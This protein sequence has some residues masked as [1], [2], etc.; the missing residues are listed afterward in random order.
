MERVQILMSTYNGEKYLKQQLDSILAQTYPNIRIFIRDDG[1][2]DGTIDI[3]KSYAERHDNIV[4]YRGNN[5]GVIQSFLELL[6]NS[7]D[8]AD[9]YGFAD[10][11]DEWLP[12]KV[13]QAVEFLRKKKTDRP[14]LYCSDTYITDENLNVIK[15]DE[16][17]PKPS[18]GNAL[19]QNI[20]TGCTAVINRSLRDIVNRTRPERIVMH[21]WWLYLTAELYGEVCY[22][23]GAYIRYRQH[24]DNRFG[25]KAGKKEIWKY[26]IH[27]LFQ[28]RGELYDQLRE[29]QLNYTDM[30]QEQRKLLE[31]V[32]QSQKGFGN[33]IRLVCN[34]KIYRNK[35]MDDKVYRGMVMIGKL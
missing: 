31:L 19:V 10:Q 11:D 1:S 6:R 26:R 20:C 29:V 18:L 30:T 35:P 23:K 25:A 14:L 7:D 9:Y 27:Q 17:C 28:K 2:S 22:D 5:I 32:L 16:K 24:G 15:K 13:A 33:R 3:L 8:L 34:R 4:Y 21:D 12:E